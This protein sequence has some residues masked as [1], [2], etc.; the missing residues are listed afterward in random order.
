MTLRP[1]ATLLTTLETQNRWISGVTCLTSE[2]E[3]RIYVLCHSPCAILVF[4]HHR[5]P[6][7]IQNE[8]QKDEIRQPSDIAASDH[9]NCLYVTDSGSGVVCP[10]VGQAAEEV[11]QPPVI[12]KITP[13]TFD[14]V[15]WLTGIEKPST[16]AVT[17][18]G[19]VLVLRWAPERPVME[20][21]SPDARRIGIISFPSTVE[22]PRHAV[23]TPSGIWIAC[24]WVRIEKIWRVCEV[25]TIPGAK[26]EHGI[27]LTTARDF[28]LTDLKKP[29]NHAY[30]LT[31]DEHQRAITADFSNDRVVLCDPHFRYCQ[32]LLT[33]T[34]HGIVAPRRVHYH[35]ENRQLLV[36]HGGHGFRELRNAL[37]GRFV[38]VYKIC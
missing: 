37:G 24:Y 27:V 17:R 7:R 6:F 26:E 30:Y 36:V 20:T 14:A 22:Y 11:E 12:W 15:R 29:L 16:L 28:D 21:Y 23:E 31:L 18:D 32:I 5:I 13:T 4:D 25:E 1:S 3:S 19:R 34:E 35:L 33:E 9:S 10:E 8:V 38:D 2:S